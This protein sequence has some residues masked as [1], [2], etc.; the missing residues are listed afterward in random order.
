MDKDIEKAVVSHAKND[1][2][3]AQQQKF[4]PLVGGTPTIEGSYSV[5]EPA[6]PEAA[7]TAARKIGEGHAMAMLR[8]GGHELTNA[9]AAFP[10]SNIR[11]MEE[12]NTFGNEALPHYEPVTHNDHLNAAAQR[13]PEPG[14]EK[15]RSR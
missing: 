13:G 9:L 2:A 11:P 5:V 12:P 4:G 10:D 8:L 1:L 14:R 3:N 6:M 15:G 7:K